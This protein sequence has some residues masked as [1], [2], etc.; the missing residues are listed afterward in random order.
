MLE[1]RDRL[2]RG[3]QR[4]GELLGE[5]EEGPDRADH[6]QPVAEEADQLADGQV[7]GVDRRA[8]RRT[9][10]ARGSMPENSTPTA[11]IAACQMP[12]GDA[13]LAGPAATGGRSC[14]RRCPR[15]RCPRR[16]RSPATMSVAS[17]VSVGGAPRSTSWRRCSGRSSGS[18]TADEHRRG[19]A[20]PAGPSGGEV[21]STMAATVEVGDQLGDR[22]GGDLGE[23]R[24]TRRRRC[25]ATL[26]TSPVGVRRGSTWPICDGLAGDHQRRAVERDQPAAHDEGVHHDAEDRAD[27][28]HHE[29][30]P[31]S[32]GAWPRSSSARIPSSTARPTSQGP[33]VIGSCHSTPTTVALATTS[34]CRPQH[35]QQEPRRRAQVR[36]AVGV[37]PGS[38]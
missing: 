13:G 10:A 15:R 9:S 26:S 18:A 38:V 5:L 14:G 36:R 4:P 29:Q 34:R 32:T 31:A 1:D 19:D 30:Q 21:S 11:S 24:R 16:I 12:G 37:S 3:D 7:A 33:T 6:E 27:Q 35:P 17:E 28:R 2:A 25:A 22:P 23:R 8:C 20:A